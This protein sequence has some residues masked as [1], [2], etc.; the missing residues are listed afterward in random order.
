M[1]KTYKVSGMTCGGCASSVTKALQRA[2]FEAEVSHDSGTA[3]VA[4]TAEDAKIKAA[5]EAAGFGYEGVL[6]T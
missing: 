6:A 2:G 5:I 1:S 4:S 3:R